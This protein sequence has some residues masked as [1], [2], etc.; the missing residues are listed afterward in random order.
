MKSKF[1]LL[2]PVI[3]ICISLEHIVETYSNGM[4]KVVKT[5]NGYGKLQLNKE[6]GYYSDGGQKYQKTYYKGELQ[7][8]YEWD[9]DGN[10]VRK[11]ILNNWNNADKEALLKDCKGDNMDYNLANGCQ[12]ALGVVEDNFESLLYLFSYFLETRNN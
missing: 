1:I 6:I 9:P 7:S 3:S 4:P 8:F 12:C 11:S 5:Y 2:I 10:K